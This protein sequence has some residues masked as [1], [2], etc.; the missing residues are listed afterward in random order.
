MPYKDPARQ[1][2]YQRRWTQRRRLD[3]L[4]ANGPCVECG[5]WFDLQVDHIDP[6]TKLNH[7]VWSWTKERREVELAKCQ[8]L[9]RPCHAKKTA[10]EAVFGEKHG[11]SVLSTEDVLEVRRR[12][13]AGE[14]MAAVG[15]DF[16]VSRKHVWDLVN[17]TRIYE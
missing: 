4:A 8:V 13:K 12:V 6:A 5:S 3:W 11:H 7:N 2:E 16:G 9:C 10:K 17:R 15:L 1:S 14:T